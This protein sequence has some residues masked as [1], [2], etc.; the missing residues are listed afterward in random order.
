MFKNILLAIGFMAA[1]IQPLKGQSIDSSKSDVSFKV[2]NMKFNTVEGTFTNMTGTIDFDGKTITHID[3]C[4]LAETVNTKSK[5]RDQHLKNED[6]FNVNVFPEICF[7][8]SEIVTQN[9]NFLAK[10]TLSLHGVSKPVEIPLTVNNK[11][12]SGTLTINR[13]DY[14]LGESTGTFMVGNE[15][16][17][18]IN[19]TVR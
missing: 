18:K 17:I 14:N 7:E 5:K 13:L 10:G 2:K 12:V 3:A 19:C 4:I 16:T 11:D 1:I 6:F 15:I 9:N 8:S